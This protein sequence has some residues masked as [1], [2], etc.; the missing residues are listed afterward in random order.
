MFICLRALALVAPGTRDRGTSRGLMSSSAL[1]P[2]ACR[3]LHLFVSSTSQPQGLLDH[4]EEWWEGGCFLH[5]KVLTVICQGRGP[6][7][8]PFQP[9]LNRASEPTVAAVSLTAPRA[10]PF[11]I[12]SSSLP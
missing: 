8:A 2:A 5:V 10:S 6:C 3:L 1:L 7:S 11:A 9:W 12:E 4:R